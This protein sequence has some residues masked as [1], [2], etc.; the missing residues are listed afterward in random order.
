VQQSVNAAVGMS[1][2]SYG[3]LMP[4]FAAAGVAL[5]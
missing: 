2:D 1:T 4:L 3:L 5:W